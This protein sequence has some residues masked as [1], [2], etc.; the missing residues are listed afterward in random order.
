M[1]ED[2]AVGEIYVGKVVRIMNFGAGV[3]IL[4]D[5]EGLLH[6]SQL[7]DH[8]VSKVEDVVNI[9]D[10]IMVKVIEIDDTGRV[11]LTRIER[12]GDRG[13]GVRSFRPQ[14]PPPPS[15]MRAAAELEGD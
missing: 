12:G 2:V 7:A 13:G 11:S 8:R 3:E 15:D 9:G 10:E 6:I 14:P 1:A 4:P 5:T